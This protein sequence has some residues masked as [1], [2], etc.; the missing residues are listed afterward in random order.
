MPLSQRVTFKTHV[1][2]K[3]RVRIPFAIKQRFKP[4]SSELI[5]V[6][7]RSG[8]QLGPK[9]TFY[10]KIRKDGCITIP[11]VNA[12]SLKVTEKMLVEITIEPA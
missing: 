1:T 9:E 2:K 11:Q 7:L 4:D 3:N 12:E 8:I 10:T 5:M 6:T